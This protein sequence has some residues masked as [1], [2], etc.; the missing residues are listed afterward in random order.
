MGR[1]S[2][3][4]PMC[5]TCNLVLATHNGLVT[6]KVAAPAPQSHYV[7]A[8]SQQWRVSGTGHEQVVLQQLQSVFWTLPPGMVIHH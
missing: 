1:P 3:R 8:G 6:T 4:A 5:C 2:G 7:N